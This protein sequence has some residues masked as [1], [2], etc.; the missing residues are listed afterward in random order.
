MAS[1]NDPKK[2]IVD[3]KYFQKV[4]LDD[5]LEPAAPVMCTVAPTVIQAEEGE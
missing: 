2:M 1:K 3:C 5:G 4:K